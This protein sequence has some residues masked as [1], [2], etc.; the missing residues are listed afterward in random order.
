[1]TMTFP[2]LSALYRHWRRHPRV[3]WLAAAYLKYR[4]GPDAGMGT[5]GGGNMEQLA[6]MFGATPGL[7]LV[8]GGKAA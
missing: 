3:E 8:Q 5:S 7:K 4:P 1:M 6:R 2:R